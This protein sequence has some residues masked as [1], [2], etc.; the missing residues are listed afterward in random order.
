M[1][2]RRAVGLVRRCGTPRVQHRRHRPRYPREPG[3]AGA[4]IEP[5]DTEVQRGTSLLVLARFH[6]ELPAE[7]ALVYEDAQGQT[8]R[9]SMSRSLDDPLFGARMDAVYE[10]LTYRVEFA[11]QTSDSY[12]V[13]VFDYPELVRADAQLVFPA[14][15]SLEPRLAQDV[16]PPVVGGRCG[17]DADLPSEQR[18]RRGPL[19]GGEEAVGGAGGR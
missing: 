1:L 2:G 19:A 13:S 9:L 4:T 3:A 12:R 18:G 8:N 11:G 14:Y 6:G 5:G 10:P 17:T 16:R 7:A 15:T